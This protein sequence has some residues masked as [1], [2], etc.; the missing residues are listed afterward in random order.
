[1]W[2]RII[3]ERGYMNSDHVWMAGSD[4]AQREHDQFAGVLTET[5]LENNK[6][7]QYLSSPN[8]NSNRLCIFIS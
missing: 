4:D 7:I 3:A 8:S 1:M 5:R 6:E 2:S